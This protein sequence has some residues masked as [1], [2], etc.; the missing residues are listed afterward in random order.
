MLSKDDFKVET[1]RTMTGK[2]LTIVTCP[3]GSEEM[4]TDQLCA[5]EW[6]RLRVEESNKPR[7]E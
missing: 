4:F 2:H 6:V 7:K 3:D 5:S 1:T